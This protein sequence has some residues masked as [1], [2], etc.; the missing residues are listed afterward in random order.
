[1]RTDELLRF[2]SAL[3]S[4]ITPLADQPKDV[5]APGTWAPHVNIIAGR[6]EPEEADAI[7]GVLALRDFAWRV[8]LTNVCL[9]PGPR[10]REWTRYD[11]PR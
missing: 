11:V 4:A 1:M 10:A 8:P 2:Q 3:A 6:I 7:T 9:V 5:Y